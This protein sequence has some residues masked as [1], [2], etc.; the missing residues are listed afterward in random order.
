MFDTF[1]YRLHEGTLF[2]RS[3][4]LPSLQNVKLSCLWGSPKLLVN[5]EQEREFWGYDRFKIRKSYLYSILYSYY[6]M[7]IPFISLAT[8][9]LSRYGC[10]WKMWRAQENRVA[11]V[12]N[13]ELVKLLEWS[14]GFYNVATRKRGTKRN[15]QA[16]SKEIC[17]IVI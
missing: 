10:T 1:V 7:K 15:K 13:R 2:A 12:N 11:R 4:V 8:V 3:F 14:M 9:R 16:A 5:N 17:E 6:D